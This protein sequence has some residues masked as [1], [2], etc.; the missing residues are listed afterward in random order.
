MALKNIHTKDIDLVTTNSSLKYVDI[1]ITDVHGKRYYITMHVAQLMAV[2]EI[3]KDN[4]M[5]VINQIMEEED[6]DN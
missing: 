4:M 1:Y 2:A 5:E 3:A 6:G